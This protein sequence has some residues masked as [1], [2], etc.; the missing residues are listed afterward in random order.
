MESGEEVSI[1]ELLDGVEQT[2]LEFEF[3]FFISHASEDDEAIA[4]PLAIALQKKKYRVWYD[5]YSIKMGDSVPRSI[6]NGIYKSKFGIVI[7]TPNFVKKKWTRTE[8]DALIEENVRRD[9]EVIL[10]ILHNLS[11][12]DLHKFSPIL[13]AKLIAAPNLG[14][15]EIVDQVTRVHRQNDIFRPDFNGSEP[16]IMDKENL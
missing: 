4:R 5:N 11:R 15:D 14:L 10:P 13:A 8:V 12:E 9:Y 6:D 16:P 1:E 2:Q 3:D 7:L